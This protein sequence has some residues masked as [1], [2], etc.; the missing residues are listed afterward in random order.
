MHYQ[1]RAPPGFELQF[2]DLDTRD[3]VK[4]IIDENRGEFLC[5]MEDSEDLE[6]KR[7]GPTRPL[8][9]R[10][11]QERERLLKDEDDGPLVIPDSEQAEF[12]SSMWEDKQFLNYLIFYTI[13]LLF[14]LV[15]T[16]FINS[17][18]YRK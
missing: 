16:F 17:N 1:Q 12:M 5:I 7:L 8:I 14:Q 15:I 4:E 11:R 18:A 3:T 6:W 10:Y 9:T 13:G 2:D